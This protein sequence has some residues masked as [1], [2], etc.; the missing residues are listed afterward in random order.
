VKLPRCTPAHAA[1][2]S[3][4]WLYDGK[5]AVVLDKVALCFASDFAN[6]ILK[7]AFT[8]YLREQEEAAKKI[9]VKQ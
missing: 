5:I 3:Q 1:E 9:V 2:F 8:S 4:Q 7:T 6:V